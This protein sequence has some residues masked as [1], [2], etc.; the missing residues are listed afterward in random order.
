M[1]IDWSADQG[2]DPKRLNVNEVVS[3]MDY[4]SSYFF[5]PPEEPLDPATASEQYLLN[6]GG[7]LPLNIS[8]A[9]H[10]G[11]D[12]EMEM[13]QIGFDTPTI[14]LNERPMHQ[15]ASPFDGTTGMLHLHS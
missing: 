15:D 7:G 11:P 9:A 6:V 14:G 2:I 3:S 8:P 5:T 4:H 13:A 10:A 1:G 12:L